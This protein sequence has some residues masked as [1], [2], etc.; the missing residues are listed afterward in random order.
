[1]TFAFCHYNVCGH[2]YCVGGSGPGEVGG[3]EEVRGRGRLWWEFECA[4][5][6]RSM[7]H[8]Q[9]QHDETGIHHAASDIIHS[10]F[11]FRYAPL[12]PRPHLTP[13]L[14]P[15][16]LT[17][18]HPHLSP[19]PLPPTTNISPLT[20]LTI[21]PLPL[22]SQPTDTFP[23]PAL[24]QVFKKFLLSEGQYLN[25]LLILTNYFVQPFKLLVAYKP[26]VLS[27]NAYQSLFLNW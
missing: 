6:G 24:Q 13:S 14:T 21:L 5:S 20:I 26:A 7:S 22:P 16:L 12:D 18:Q 1:M 10:S 27:F 17:T 9:L 23:P 19:T 11:S 25:N 8:W 3:Y 15:T 2:V 4:C